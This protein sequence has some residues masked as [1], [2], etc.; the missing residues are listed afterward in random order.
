MDGPIGLIAADAE[1][2]SSIGAAVDGP[3]ASALPQSFIIL[4]QN[5]M[6]FPQRQLDYQDNDDDEENVTETKR[7][8]FLTGL[9]SQMEADIQTGLEFIED[10]RQSKQVSGSNYTIEERK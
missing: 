9:T 1:T 8:F 10:S 4:A 2:L 6:V 3:P 5:S 7:K